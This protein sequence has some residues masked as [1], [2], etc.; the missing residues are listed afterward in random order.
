MGGFSTGDKNKRNYSLGLTWVKATMLDGLVRREILY[1]EG[2][3]ITH[4]NPKPSRGGRP[5]FALRGSKAEGTQRSV[6]ALTLVT[7]LSQ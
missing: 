4:P 5:N 1:S 6:Q 3:G 7:T 2:R